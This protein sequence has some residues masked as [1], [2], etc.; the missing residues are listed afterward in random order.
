MQIEGAVQKVPLGSLVQLPLEMFEAGYSKDQ[1]LEADREGA[2]LAEAAGYS[3]EG[4]ISMFRKFQKLEDEVTRYRTSGPQ[5]R[6]VLTLPIELGNVVV[7][8][9]LEGYF[10]T[11]PP[12]SERIAQMERLMAAEHWPRDQR[13]KTLAVGYLLMTEQARRYFATDQ[14]D[15]ALDSARKTLTIKPDYAPALL[16]VADV[17]FERA[18]FTGAAEMYGRAMRLDPKQDQVAV[19]YDTSLSASLPA[20]EALARYTELA[21]GYPELRERAW[22]AEEQAGLKLMTGDAAAARSLAQ[23]LQAS[24]AEAAPILLGRLGWWYYRFGNIGTA[25][26]LIGQAVEQRPQV[27]WLSAKLGWVRIAQ[28]KYESAQQRFYGIGRADDE[29]TRAEIEM[30]I[31][32]SAWNEGQ[33]DVAVS[34]FR[35]AAGQRAAWLNPQWVT[36]LYGPQISATTQAIHAQS[37]RQKKAQRAAKS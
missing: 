4:A 8:K 30:G 10:R 6:T 3:A 24:D 29:R 37:E 2:K 32:V 17:H 18:D 15:K 20:M 1:E 33:P 9:T 28:K 25:A 12:E 21:D 23:Q 5:R 22:F 35:G 31:A 26:D 13:Q 7:L 27:A 14:L 36:A 16:I 11:H 19:L 34:N